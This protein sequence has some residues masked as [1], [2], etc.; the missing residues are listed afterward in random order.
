R[1]TKL[2]ELSKALADEAEKKKG[3]VK[4]F[5]ETKLVELSLT[6]SNKAA[7][8]ALHQAE[9]ELKA[10]QGGAP[11]QAP[12]PDAN[13]AAPPAGGQAPPAGGQAPPVGGETPK[14]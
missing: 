5:D 11:G 13:P 7:T 9:A 1:Q 12:P 6:E 2:T 3:E 14:P 10:Q 8:K 4:A